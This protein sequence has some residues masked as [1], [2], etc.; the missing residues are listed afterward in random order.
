MANFEYAASGEKARL[1][2]FGR[3]FQQPVTGKVEN[4]HAF[5][6]FGVKRPIFAAD[7]ADG[8]G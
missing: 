6:V 7:V 4:G 1:F 3:F 8:C 2:R 5:A